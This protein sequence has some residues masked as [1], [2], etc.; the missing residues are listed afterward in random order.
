[1]S[2]NVEDAM[3][4]LMV[5]MLRHVKKHGLPDN[6]TSYLFKAAEN[7]AN[8]FLTLQRRHPLVAGDERD[9]EGEVAA[10]SS[11]KG[12]FQKTLRAE[13]MER[14]EE[15][16]AKLS[17]DDATVIRLAHFGHLTQEEIAEHLGIS[18]EAVEKRYER[19][20]PKLQKLVRRDCTKDDLEEGAA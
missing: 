11:R 18:V 17:D 2:S 20:I 9:G 13:R 8:Y 7:T 15:G 6:P 3:Q 1:K 10:P 14:V 19:A 5:A 12:L 16:L 4:Q